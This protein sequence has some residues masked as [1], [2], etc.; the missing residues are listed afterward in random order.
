MLR[1]ARRKYLL[2]HFS[3]N[4]TRKI[5]ALKHRFSV[6]PSLLKHGNW[7]Y[8][9]IGSFK[10]GAARSA[11]MTERW[12]KTSYSNFFGQFVLF[13]IEN[14]SERE[15]ILDTNSRYFFSIAQKFA[16]RTYHVGLSS[17]LVL[18]YTSKCTKRSNSQKTVDSCRYFC[19]DRT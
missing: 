1:N 13:Y 9:P 6:C 14:N 15:T 12:K 7:N 11:E 8:I 16:S 19:E 18:V 2:K 4:F 17:I 3:Q 10:T 5:C